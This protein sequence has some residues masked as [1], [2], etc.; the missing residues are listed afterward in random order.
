MRVRRRHLLLG[1]LLGIVAVA[2]PP[3]ASSSE[4]SPLIEAINVPPYYHYWSPST[5]SSGGTVTFQNRSTTE[6]GLVWN[7]GNPETPS[8]SGIPLNE[9]AANWKGSCTFKQS[10]TYT[11]H[12]YVHPTEMTGT[13]TV[14]I[15]G[16]PT[17]TSEAASTV[18]QTEATL[19]G[20]VNPE[21]KATEYFFEWGTSSKYGQKTEELSLGSEDHSGHAVSAKL[22]GL[23][24]GTPYHFRVVAKNGVG[25]T[26]GDD[27]T[28]TTEA[29]PGS[30]FATTDP[31]TAPS[32][33]EATLNG[34]INPDGEATEYFFEWGT[35]SG[36]GQKTEA[37]SLGSE[38]HA[39][40]GVSAKLTALAAG[41]PYHF[42]LVAKNASGTVPGNDR[43]FTTVSSPPAPTQT[44]PPPSTTPTSS[45][46][47]TQ[48][49]TPPPATTTGTT[50]VPSGSLIVGAPSLRS[51]Q[52]GTSIGGSLQVSAAGAGG[53]LEIDLFAK[54]ATLAGARHSAAARVGRLVRS[55]VSA[56][57]VSFVVPLD[58]AARRALKRLRHLAVSVR[59]TLTPKHGRVETVIRSVELR[60]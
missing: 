27:Q 23:M 16:T 32:E 37:L 53:R 51:T 58:A 48:S 54:G 2:L 13:I 34:T 24:P 7:A 33:T 30:P 21:G 22:P 42:R 50:E 8:C 11:F 20:T 1:V 52:H 60:G 49:T 12:C 18:S 29:P 59:I 39:G 56:G 9:G 15:P 55:S 47:A 4:T 19:N 44:A 46:T 31:A 38:D 45:P 26:L 41:T 14:T 43:E 10:G 35:T 17:V 57:K 6:H 28:F 36:Y 25:T 40:H 5:A 3:I